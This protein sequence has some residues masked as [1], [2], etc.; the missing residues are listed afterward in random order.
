MTSIVTGLNAAP[1][2]QL[3]RS[4][5]LVSA[6]YMGQLTACKTLV[7]PG[8]NFKNYRHILANISPL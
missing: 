5:E 3:K 2:H 4:W 8:R 1:V 6:Q 7:D